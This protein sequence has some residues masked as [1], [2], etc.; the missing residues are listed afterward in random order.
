MG[1]QYHFMELEFC[2]GGDIITEGLKEEET[3]KD[4]CF[5]KTETAAFFYYKAYFMFILHAHMPVFLSACV[6]VWLFICVR[7]T[8]TSTM[9]Q[10]NCIILPFL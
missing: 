5:K 4:L 6:F 1:Y 2:C 10:L 7:Y 3:H 9:I 8:N